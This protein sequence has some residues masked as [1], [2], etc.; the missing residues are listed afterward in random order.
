MAA[1]DD[2]FAAP[3]LTALPV[4][5]PSPEVPKP[6]E[7][8]DSVPL[9]SQ[10]PLSSLV[11]R[12]LSDDWSAAPA[13]ASTSTIQ[14]LSSRPARRARPPA[15][16]PSVS[17]RKR[18]EAQL[19]REAMEMSKRE[20][21]LQSANE[22]PHEEQRSTT[23]EPNDAD[24]EI[25]DEPSASP[26]LRRKRGR[27]ST[28]RAQSASPSSPPTAPAHVAVALSRTGR[29]PNYK[30]ASDD[31]DF[32]VSA[33]ADDEVDTADAE[34]EA[35]D[36]DGGGDDDGDAVFESLLIADGEQDDLTRKWRDRV[37]RGVTQTHLERWFGVDGVP[38]EFYG[39][40]GWLGRL[41]AG[42]IVARRFINGRHTT[43][44]V[45]GLDSNNDSG[46]VEKAAIEVD[47][48]FWY[49]YSV[50]GQSY[51]H[52][53]WLPEHHLLQFD[54][55]TGRITHFNKKRTV[56]EAELDVTFVAQ[57]PPPQ[58]TPVS[59]V[60][61]E[62]GGALAADVTSS[63]ENGQVHMQHEPQQDTSS[64]GSVTSKSTATSP[65]T[66]DQPCITSTHSGSNDAT[67]TEPSQPHTHA[68]AAKEA[69][70]LA[71]FLAKEDE[72]KLARMQD[73]AAEREDIRRR[74]TAAPLFDVDW[75]AVDRVMDHRRKRKER[76]QK[77]DGSGDRT[78]KERVQEQL[79]EY[80][81]R[82]HGAALKFIRAMQQHSGSEQTLDEQRT[83]SAVADGG[84]TTAEPEAQ[85]GA[86]EADGD[87]EDAPLV[88][89]SQRVEYEFLVKWKK[90]S[91]D[92]CTWET[93]TFLST[94]HIDGAVLAT[95]LATT[96]LP[97]STVSSSPY[98]SAVR[99]YL[100]LVSSATIRPAGWLIPQT[101]RARA[102]EA[103]A[104]R[105]QSHEQKLADKQ[106]SDSDDDNHESSHLSSSSPPRSATSHLSA[107]SSRPPV[108]SS[109][110][111][112]PSGLSLRPYQV[113]GV[114][115]IV[116]NWLTSR[117]SILADEMGLGKTAQTVAAIDYMLTRHTRQL[118]GPVLVV[119]P[120]T[121]LEFW[122]REV[123][124]FSGL[125]ACVYSGSAESR[126]IIRKHEWAWP[127]EPVPSFAEV[128]AGEVAVDDAETLPEEKRRP[129]RPRAKPVRRPLR[130]N[131]VITSYTYI[132]NDLNEL[133]RLRPACLIV[134]ESQ[135]LKSM[136]SLVYRQLQ[137][138]TTTQHKLL[139]SGT[140]IQNNMTEL[141]ALLHFVQPD[142]YPSLDEFL[143]YTSKLS[144]A[145]DWAAFTATLKPFLLRRWKAEVEKSLP[146]KE[147]VLV[148]VEL[149]MVQKK[150]YRAMYERNLRALVGATK[151]SMHNVHIQLR[152]VCLHPWLLDRVEAEEVKGCVDEDSVMERMISSS[153][154]V[155]LLDKFLPRLRREGHR[156]LIFSQMTRMLTLI[157]DYLVYRHY[158]YCRLDGRVH[159]AQREEAVRRFE[160]PN[161][162]VFCF[163]LSTRAGGLGL[164]LTSA[165]TVII[166]DS[167][168]NLMNDAQAI[169]RA[170]RIGQTKSV[171][172]Y[173]LLTTHSYEY[174]M[175][176]KASLKLTLDK[177]V[178]T[179]IGQR[180]GEGAGEGDSAIAQGKGKGKG[181]AKKRTSEGEGSGAKA[182]GGSAI[183]FDKAE[184]EELLRR[185]AYDVFADQDGDQR[186][187]QFCDD[188]IDKILNR[189]LTISYT[190]S[191]ST[192]ASTLPS[193]D[194]A[195]SR[196]TFVPSGASEALAL[197]DPNFWSKLGL[198]DRQAAVDDALLLHDRRQRRQTTYNEDE[199]ERALL[200]SAGD[201]RR[202]RK[203][204]VATCAGCSQPT[205]MDDPVPIL[206]C[207][208]CSEEWHL[209]CI[210]PPLE[211]V[212]GEEVEWLC[213]KCVA[214]RDEKRKRKAEKL[215][216]LANKRR[217]GAQGWNGETAT[218]AG[219]HTAATS[220]EQIAALAVPAFCVTGEER[221]RFFQLLAHYCA[222]YTQAPLH[223]VYVTVC[224]YL[225]DELLKRKRLVQETMQQQA[226]EALAA[227]G[228]E[229]A[230]GPMATGAVSSPHS[231]DTAAAT[232]PFDVHIPTRGRRPKAQKAT[233]AVTA[234]VAQWRQQSRQQRLD[235]LQRLEQALELLT[236]SDDSG[237]EIRK[238]S[239]TIRRQMQKLRD[240]L[241][242]DQ[243]PSQ[244]DN[245]LT[246][247][248]SG[249][250]QRNGRRAT[251]DVTGAAT[252][253]T[254][255]PAVSSAVSLSSAAVSVDEPNTS[256]AVRAS[257]R[258]SSSAVP[259][260]A[261]TAFPSTSSEEAYRLSYLA[262]ERLN[263]GGRR[264]CWG[265]G[266]AR[267]E[268]DGP[269]GLFSVCGACLTA[270]YCGRECQ[271]GHWRG[272][273][274][275]EC[276]RIARAFQHK[277]APLAAQ[278]AE[279]VQAAA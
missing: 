271:V 238:S 11:P 177:L 119:A 117:N 144:T 241:E 37:G 213:I 124:R 226:Q 208:K 82:M 16:S 91:Y 191:S 80:Q 114:N 166:Y 110:R 143:A 94:A 8:S 224:T 86:E 67:E 249:S 248:P 50:R 190:D 150:Y 253:P 131:V 6:T 202:T 56:E 116:L 39:L 272:G 227:R 38:D 182:T 252:K 216:E 7:A 259:S 260:S 85:D 96:D 172:V 246:R 148:N 247:Q 20:A 78:R 90:L 162:D 197:D 235:R 109:M 161:S 22:Q 157:E 12:R 65:P 1:I 201:G 193:V 276:K 3:S 25:V 84:E 218:A 265:V 274:V 103:S 76:R 27:S 58:P 199:L 99:D 68:D 273:H 41:P 74:R 17:A 196:A 128:E 217:K 72:R 192:S 104:E 55:S 145:D 71:T 257:T 234:E 112:G 28:K 243:Q 122:R 205:S 70:D 160:A 62:K 4:A 229:S 43:F 206:L 101:A 34:V 188:D 194:S 132:N 262:H 230:N 240:E 219:L 134:D 245:N 92:Q 95:P 215:A 222:F 258:S 184:L 165:D 88:A 195:F 106:S 45:H 15:G 233:A 270:C 277:V 97:S 142:R 225:Q 223:Q 49:L 159:G 102:A 118:D 19:L 30:E 169:D 210:Q 221:D 151:Q 47:G 10:S 275:T 14:T 87:D 264:K 52:C 211:S 61:E 32:D 251:A 21:A 108:T 168:W 174:E 152:K 278:S 175:F 138:L 214:T 23:D 147:E 153:G 123:E 181:R 158:P 164:T 48:C 115:W 79:E 254:P 36:A 105:R 93:F 2:M 113:D 42:R 207:D 33:A 120:L 163:L 18:A 250:Q 135:R 129:G 239:R 98:M 31:D 154:K 244:P 266:C 173:R 5:A 237:S 63:V 170:H 149:T 40:N 187:I 228:I 185:G 200:D 279:D 107:L 13:V 146:P 232:P 9:S 180:V 24:M 75:L 167:D 46:A 255:K 54:D 73:I 81:K 69:A 220:A 26:P 267:V 155:V 136:D 189:S 261:G 60:S 29:R 89:G 59:A 236:A 53:R 204:K 126:R 44:A 121:T 209:N 133:E 269:V 179:G 35:V 156:V 176:H 212:P 77:K 64:N 57:L 130:V 256:P 242:R 127:D 268:E 263:G 183:P 111:F 66:T 203:R 139:L 178:M 198:V 125:Y 186:S 51:L 137:R 231:V 141:F 140:P 83:E 171:R 100:A